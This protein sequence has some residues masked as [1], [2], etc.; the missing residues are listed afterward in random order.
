MGVAERMQLRQG[1]RG[2]SDAESRDEAGGNTNRQ[3]TSIL[4]GDER[5]GTRDQAHRS[6]LGWLRGS[7]H[8]LVLSVG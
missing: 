6:N 7:F 5:G 4:A 2:R 1:G 8:E 3:A